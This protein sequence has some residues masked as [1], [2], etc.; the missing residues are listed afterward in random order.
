M[1]EFSFADLALLVWA[2]AATAAAFDYKNKEQMARMIIFKIIEDPTLYQNMCDNF[3]E[4]KKEFLQ[5][6]KQA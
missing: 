2:V 1:I 3:L 5:R 4:H 6:K